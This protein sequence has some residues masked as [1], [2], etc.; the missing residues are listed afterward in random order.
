MSNNNIGT[1]Y[2]EKKKKTIINEPALKR[3]N[4]LGFI[5]NIIANMIQSILLFTISA[6]AIVNV[7]NP[8]YMTA[9]GNFGNWSA[10]DINLSLIHI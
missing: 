3:P 8:K 2:I 4:Y 6:G 10:T 7:N 9:S 1:D 5:T